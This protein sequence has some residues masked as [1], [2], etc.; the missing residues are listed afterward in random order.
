MSARKVV[1]LITSC[2]HICQCLPRCHLLFDLQVLVDHKADVNASNAHGAT[3]MHFAANCGQAS[4]IVYLLSKVQCVYTHGL[5]YKP[6]ISSI[7]CSLLYLL[8]A[9][10]LMQLTTRGI[11]L[12][13][14]QRNLALS[15][16][17]KLCS[18]GGHMQRVL[19]MRLVRSPSTLHSIQKWRTLSAAVHWHLRRRPL[20]L[21]PPRLRESLLHARQEPGIISPQPSR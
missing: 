6:S 18:Q 17:S 9:P 10:G 21:L 20:A 5:I 2:F 13:T 8:R 14:S 1:L 19:P 3:P 15:A 4:V 16:S 7:T 11:R 12:F